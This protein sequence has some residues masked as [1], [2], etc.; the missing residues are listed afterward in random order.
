MRLETIAHNRIRM[1]LGSPVHI[2][3]SSIKEVILKISL[4]LSLKRMR[5]KKN[6]SRTQA[7]RERSLKGNGHHNE[8]KEIEEKER[9]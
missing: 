4:F 9:I 2:S 5:Y 8:R 7:E 6:S 3:F 1:N